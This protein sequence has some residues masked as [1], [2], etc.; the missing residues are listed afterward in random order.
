M[1]DIAKTCTANVADIEKRLWKYGLLITSPTAFL[2]CDI[3]MGVKGI[4]Y[5]L[6]TLK[7][8]QTNECMNTK[9]EI[10]KNL[11]IVDRPH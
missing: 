11:S 3:W 10:L 5:N 9:E 1:G 7:L 2:F 4:V 6:L 8:F